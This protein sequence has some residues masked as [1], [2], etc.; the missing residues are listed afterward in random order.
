[1]H[2]IELHIYLGFNIL[3]MD[4]HSQSVLCFFLEALISLNAF[5]LR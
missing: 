4:G 2:H 1:M 3:V 5:S